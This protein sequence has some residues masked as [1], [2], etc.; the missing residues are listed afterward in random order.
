MSRKKNAASIRTDLER[1][2]LKQSIQVDELTGIYNRKAL[3]EA[4]GCHGGS[5]TL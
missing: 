5:K 4:M 2:Q 1:H 3:D